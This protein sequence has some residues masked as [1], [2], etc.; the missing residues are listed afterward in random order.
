[1]FSRWQIVAAA[2]LEPAPV[3]CASPQGSNRSLH[4]KLYGIRSL[5]RPCPATQ[6]FSR[7]DY[8]R[9]TVPCAFPQGKTFFSNLVIRRFAPVSSIS[10]RALRFSA[11]SKVFIAASSPDAKTTLTSFSARS[12]IVSLSSTYPAS[13][14]VIFL[15]PKLSKNVSPSIVRRVRDSNS[16]IVSDCLVSS[17]VLSTTQPTLRASLRI[18]AANYLSPPSI[19]AAFLRQNHLAHFTSPFSFPS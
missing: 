2:G 1:M 9:Y 6:Q 14:W 19:L 17:K 10:R 8:R 16:R 15:C 3:P 5:R 18:L 4:S 12:S 13:R 7:D 11:R